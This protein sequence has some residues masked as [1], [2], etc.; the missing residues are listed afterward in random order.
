VI[1][2]RGSYNDGCRRKQIRWS[3]AE[4]WS[5]LSR[6]RVVYMTVHIHVTK[7]KRTKSEPSGKKG[8]FVGY[9]VSHMEIDCEEQKAPKDDRTDPS[10]SVD[11]SSDHQEES[12]EPRR[13]YP[14]TL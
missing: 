8:T 3:L 9:R 10:S 11:H 14:E 4:T 12:V 7:E 6:H 1:A 2:L 5:R 13:A